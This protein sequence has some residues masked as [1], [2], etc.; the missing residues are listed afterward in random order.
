[1]S[2]KQTNKRKPNKNYT[3]CEL[4]SPLEVFQSISNVAVKA[5]KCIASWD[6]EFQFCKS[7]S[8]KETRKPGERW[9]HFI[10]DSI[11]NSV[12]LTPQLSQTEKQFRLASSQQLVSM[13][14]QY[15]EDGFK[16]ISSNPQL[17]NFIS[18]HILCKQLQVQ[19]IFRFYGTA[20][21]L[22]LAKADSV[23]IKLWQWT[24]LDFFY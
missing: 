20:Q 11:C 24:F 6:K 10:W 17:C 21:Y 7:Q 12:W 13:W 4:R 9:K 19:D 18:A 22:K 5:V 8:L 3:F 16:A 14:R 15:P 1:M 2:L 23:S